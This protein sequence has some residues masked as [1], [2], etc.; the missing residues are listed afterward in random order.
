VSGP[1]AGAAGA[2]AAGAGAGAVAGRWRAGAVESGRGG[3]RPLPC[4]RRLAY[5]EQ[6]RGGRARQ[7]AGS[8]AS[9]PEVGGRGG[10]SWAG[11]RRSWAGGR[12]RSWAAKL[13][14]N[15]GGGRSENNREET[16]ERKVAWGYF[17]AR[18]QD[19]WRRARCRHADCHVT[20]LGAIGYGAEPCYLGATAY[21]AEHRVQTCK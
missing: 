7:P 17:L 8:Q 13:G 4:A 3:E 5:G 12:R 20:Y 11:G 6:A 15:G 9:S 1:G 2:G 14:G 18:R 10:R 19:L 16:A 21:G